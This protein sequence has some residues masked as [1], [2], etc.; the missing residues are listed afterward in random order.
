MFGERYVEK[1]VPRDHNCARRR[2]KRL[3]TLEY[4]NM[5]VPR[6]IV[7]AMVQL[8]ATINK[9][10]KKDPPSNS[11]SRFLVGTCHNIAFDSC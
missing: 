2:T 6:T 5:A 7:I 1:P 3:A 11:H 9:Q 10:V 4:H 8:D